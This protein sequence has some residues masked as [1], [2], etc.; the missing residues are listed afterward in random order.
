MRS[1]GHSH[2]ERKPADDYIEAKNREAYA[3]FETSRNFVHS[4]QPGRAR[5]RTEARAR[6]DRSIGLGFKP[7]FA[8]WIAPLPDA[9]PKNG[10]ANSHPW[11]DLQAR[12]LNRKRLVCWFGPVVKR[13]ITLASV[14]GTPRAAGCRV[15]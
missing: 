1:S 8:S 4:L 10:R 9:T 6:R 14:T 3:D 13:P 7:L 5:T 12:R 11:R 2:H 15:G